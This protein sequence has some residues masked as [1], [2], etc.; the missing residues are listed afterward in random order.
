LIPTF[1]FGDKDN[2][3]ANLRV[4]LNRPKLMNYIHLHLSVRIADVSIV[5]SLTKDLVI[6]RIVQSQGKNLVEDLKDLRFEI[7][8]VDLSS[9][10]VKNVL[11][12]LKVSLVVRVHP[13]DSHSV[14]VNGHFVYIFIGS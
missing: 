10:V 9:Y 8:R 3:V 13:F 11:N 12:I 14:L 5:N 7:R 2:F 1:N 4:Y 6:E